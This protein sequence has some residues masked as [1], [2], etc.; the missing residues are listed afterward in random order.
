MQHL[1]LI[2]DVSKAKCF[3]YII[4]L[5]LVQSLKCAGQMKFVKIRVN[6]VIGDQMASLQPLPHIH[7]S[8][9]STP[10]TGPH[11]LDTAPETGPCSSFSSFHMPSNLVPT[12]RTHE[13]QSTNS[14]PQTGSLLF[15]IAQ[16]TGTLPNFPCSAPCT[17]FLQPSTHTLVNKLDAAN[18]T[19]HVNSEMSIFCATHP[20]SFDPALAYISQ[21]QKPA[22]SSCFCYDVTHISQLTKFRGPASSPF[23]F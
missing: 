7:Q 17:D 13:Y 19:S 11:L 1:F 12:N 8:A 3:C 14:M 21:R 18:W 5:Y 2:V 6:I 23:L 15:I 22:L 9:Y 4:I 10:Q 16:E 20:G